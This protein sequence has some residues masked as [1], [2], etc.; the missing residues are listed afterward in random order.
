MEQR[1]IRKNEE[2]SATESQAGA[3]QMPSDAVADKSQSSPEEQLRQYEAAMRDFH[4]NASAELR[5][6]TASEPY[7]AVKRAAGRF[8]ARPLIQATVG[9]LF[10]LFD[11]Q[12]MWSLPPKDQDRA[13]RD[14]AILELSCNQPRMSRAALDML[15]KSCSSPEAT[16]SAA[17]PSTLKPKV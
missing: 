14:R 12:P 10:R 1:A 11:F 2:V 3:P 17:A 8:L 5:R 9:R 6:R 16:R 7:K 13:F 15:R 4:E